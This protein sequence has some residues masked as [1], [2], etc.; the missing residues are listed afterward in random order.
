[1][2]NGVGWEWL[3]MKRWAEC[4]ICSLE[5]TTEWQALCDINWLSDGVGSWLEY[6]R[7]TLIPNDRKHIT[8]SRR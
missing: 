3:L 6:W 7:M 2:V 1:M 4:T 5:R 8:Y